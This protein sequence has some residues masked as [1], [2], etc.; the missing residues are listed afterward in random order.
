MLA[1]C[2]GLGRGCVEVGV[3]RHLGVDRD[4]STPREVND[5]VRPRCRP[6]SVPGDV[7]LRAEVKVFGE[8]GCLDD[9]TK[10]G[11]APLPSNARTPQ[12]F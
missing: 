9:L 2:R 3:E 12:G 10:R 6:V 7:R 8:A 1:R 11:L 4:A 5:E